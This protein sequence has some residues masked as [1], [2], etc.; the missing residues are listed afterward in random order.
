MRLGRLFAA[1]AIAAFAVFARDLSA[2]DTW[3]LPASMRVPVGKPVM[4]SLTSGMAFPVDDFV[5]DA[6][7]ITRANVRLAGVTSDLVNPTPASK[8]LHF[9]WTPATSGVA[10]FAVELAP[11]VL[12]LA[13]DKIEEYFADINAQKELRAEW[14]RIP[15]PRA[16][17]ESYTKHA[18]SFVQVGEAANATS[19]RQPT[20]MGFE[21]VPETNP[22]TVTAGQLFK[23]RVMR[24]GKGVAGLQVGRQREGETA[25]EFTTTD[26]GGHASMKLAR[27]GRWLVNV[28]DL[29]RANRPDLEW[30]SDFATL[31][32]GVAP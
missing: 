22:V 25:V 16:W 14:E 32:I 3:L 21:I 31:T 1:F 18:S 24:N 9:E 29:R 28:T 20:G 5:I 7:R 2:H 26:A 23:V 17:R 11:K 4:L 6:K 8:S 19:W 27:A 30:Q 12:T 13:P 10:V 15:K